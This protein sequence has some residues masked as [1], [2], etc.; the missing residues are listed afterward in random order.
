RRTAE[1]GDE[2]DLDRL[3]LGRSG[4]RRKQQSGARRKQSFTH[5]FPPP[6]AVPAL[7]AMAYCIGFAPVRSTDVGPPPGRT[8]VPRGPR[9][10][11][12]LVCHAAAAIDRRASRPA[13]LGRGYGLNRE[14]LNRVQNA[15]KNL[16]RHR[17]RRRPPRADPRHLSRQSRTEDLAGGAVA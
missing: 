12:R 3:L 11:I 6:G 1:R 13:L 9:K 10:E 8:I 17:H 4:A 16:R 15:R 14:T 2:T 5:V 7:F